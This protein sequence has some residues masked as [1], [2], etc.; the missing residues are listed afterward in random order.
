MRSL[1]QPQGT[2]RRT[3]RA[4]TLIEALLMV[5]ILSVIAVGVG[6]SL[7]GAASS[8]EA[9]ENTL[10]IDNALVAQMET[11]RATWQSYAL[12]PQTSQIT[13]GNTS[14]T[15]TIDIE[16]A[17]PNGSG[18]QSTFFSLSVQIAGRTIYT[19]VSS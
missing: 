4:Y 17:A 18:V 5:V 14:Y 15:M 12:G 7:T 19:Y 11:L 6:N 16:Q 2:P 1:R 3:G 10:L 13:I 8:T 9:N